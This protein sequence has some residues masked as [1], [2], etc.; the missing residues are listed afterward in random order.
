MIHEDQRD[1]RR[2]ERR[3]PM[4]YRSGEDGRC[5]VCDTEL[6]PD[7]RGCPVC[8]AQWMMGL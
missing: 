3:E 7:E 8:R 4:P 6:R 1:E 2:D 5:P